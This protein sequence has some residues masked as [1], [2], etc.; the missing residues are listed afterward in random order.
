[1]PR[2]ASLSFKS[3]AADSGR[4][5]L[6]N[7]CVAEISELALVKFVPWNGA[8]SLVGREVGV[9]LLWRQYGN[10]Q[11]PERS[12]RYHRRLTA[13]AKGP[14]WLRLRAAGATQSRRMTSTYELT[15][16]VDERQRLNLQVAA[17]LD[18]A[19]GDGWLV[20]PHADH[21]EVT[22]C[23]LWPAGVFS[24]DGRAPKRFQCCLASRGAKMR[25]IEHHHLESPDKHRIALR[26]GDRFAWAL[27][28]INPVLTIGP[29]APVLA[30]L[31]AYMWDAH[32]G[33][34]TCPDHEAVTLPPGTVLTADYTL[35]AVTRAELAPA[36]K[37]AKL[38][39]PGRA[40]DTPV[41]TGGRHT[42]KE[43]FR[44]AD[45]DRNTAWPWATAVKAGPAEAV[46]FARE[47]GF[48]ASDRY[49]LRIH[50][51]AKAASRWLATTLGPAFGEPPFRRGGKLLLRALVFTRG[52]RGTVRVAL[53]V[54]RQGR[55][56]VFDVAGYETHP[57]TT[58]SAD[59]G[60]WTEL[61]VTTPAL[62]PAPDRV[63]V[64]LELNGE[65]RVW[66]DNVELVRLD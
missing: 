12:A 52:L 5:L 63:H 30:G 2:G 33:L 43:T 59:Q 56:S 36:V 10:H 49:S 31:C 11:D 14:G 45:I 7:R 35:S 3:T 44:G 39:S 41:W 28:D 61:S 6:G 18:V 23:T 64:L 47:R 22:F 4:I 60:K 55:G 16:G 1:M 54:H 48:G 46:E 17:R 38:L 21:G 66:F 20:T 62:T 40:A 51:R 13:Q 42:F 34:R 24:A 8:A 32:F 15:F 19:S 26:A 53:R 57:S 29:G 65:G 50:H 9:P 58:Q 25:R 37:R 27:E